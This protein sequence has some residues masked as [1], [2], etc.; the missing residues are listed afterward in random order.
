MAIVS[1]MRNAAKRLS[2][3]NGTNGVHKNGAPAPLKTWRCSKCGTTKIAK[4]RPYAC[5][6]CSCTLTFEQVQAPAPKPPPVF[7]DEAEQSIPLARIQRNPENPRTEFDP[8][9]LED[10][11]ASI[12]E[13]GLLSA[14]LVRPDPTST[15]KEHGYQLVDG[16]R[17]FR[18]AGMAGLRAIP[19]KVRNLT[20]AEVLQ[21]M[22]VSFEH[23]KDISVFEKADLYY[24]LH[25]THKLSVEDIAK[26]IGRSLS[27]VRGLLKIRHVPEIIRQAVKSGHLPPVTAQLI[28][29][30]PDEKAQDEVARYVLCCGNEGD[31]YSDTPPT[32][33]DAKDYLKEGRSPM[34]VRETKKL[35]EDK[36]MVELKGAPFD[37]ASMSLVIVA[38]SCDGCP[39]RV[40]NLAKSDP[41]AYAGVRADMCTDPGCFK[42]KCAAHQ[43]LQEAQAKAKGQ[44]LLTAKQAAK[45]FSKYYRDE[46]DREAPYVDLDAKFDKDPKRRTIGEL[47]GKQAK[48]SIQIAFDANGKQHRLLARPLAAQLLKK[49]CKIT[50]AAK[51]SVGYHS[52][53]PDDWKRRQEQAH[54]DRQLKNET[55]YRCLEP[56]AT[57]AAKI[58][59]DSPLAS[60]RSN[61]PALKLLRVI[62]I[63]TM[64]KSYAVLA[65][66]AA[67]RGLAK[68][69][70]TPHA[71]KAM[72]KA[73]PSMG[74]ADL[75]GLL[76][77]HQVGHALLSYYASAEE[78]AILAHLEIDVAA[79]GKK[80]KAELAAAGKTEEAPAK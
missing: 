50:I 68:T 13:F 48:D 54:R 71:D 43:R 74:A 17:R 55:A 9:E 60:L 6:K 53:D 41:E 28:A 20:D 75:I 52:S 33:E 26:R 64:H 42:E 35:I 38:G 58:A 8:Q 63:N 2:G 46:L 3:R 23:R 32:L 79:I 77:E 39:K 66:M 5:N 25:L 67:R 51:T 31:Y 80:A 78:K 21:I 29:R 4:T 73:I 40:G 19:A 11:A 49:H 56:A 22:A 37:R 18:A 57:A 72:L 61:S 1:A 65:A 47:I 45:V 30:V 7:G 62:A 69:R 44:T 15:G 27:T 76:A 36:Y 16:E 70:L 10:L 59:A 24:K 34:S 14:I 12:R